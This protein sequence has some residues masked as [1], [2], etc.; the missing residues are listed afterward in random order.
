MVITL[1]KYLPPMAVFSCK[2]PQSD[3]NDSLIFK[4][5]STNLAENL[6]SIEEPIPYVRFKNNY[7]CS[8]SME[9]SKQYKNKD[10]IICNLTSDELYLEEFHY[11]YREVVENTRSML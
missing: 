11:K 5:V 3:H 7:N 2:H 6:S 8:I 10:H 9:Q 4:R 1:F